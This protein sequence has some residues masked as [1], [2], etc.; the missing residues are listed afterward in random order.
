MIEPVLEVM[1]PATE[2][3]ENPSCVGHLVLLL[4][5]LQPPQHRLRKGSNHQGQNLL[6]WDHYNCF[7]NISV[8]RAEDRGMLGNANKSVSDGRGSSGGS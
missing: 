7:D 6:K 8:A 3:H 1:V 2:G 5:F 4:A